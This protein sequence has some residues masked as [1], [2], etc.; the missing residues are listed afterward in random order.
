MPT[1]PITA[2]YRLDHLFDFR[3]SGKVRL[4][5]VIAAIILLQRP[6]L[7]A[8]EP[9]KASDDITSIALFVLLPFL[10]AFAFIVFVVYRQ[11][12]EADVKQQMT[13]TELKALRAQMN[14]HFIFNC[15]NSI[16]LLVRNNENKPAGEYLLKFSAIMRKVL[17]S[18]M[19]GMVTVNEDLKTLALYL[20]LE[21]LR[22]N[23][24]FEFQITNELEEEGD[25][26]MVPP[27]LVQPFAENSIWHGFASKPSG[28][29]IRVHVARKGDELLITVTDN[30]EKN[31]ANPNPE[32][33]ALKKASHSGTI[34]RER[35]EAL[36]MLKH[37]RARYTT[38]EQLDQHGTYAGCQVQL[39][40]PC[41]IDS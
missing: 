12:R 19:A 22:T 10:V 31:N 39:Y 16:Y 17:D 13:E 23:M 14:P 5:L 8:Q 29:V 37:S 15:L 3:L 41:L 11:K 30:G 7:I 6:Q 38:S 4:C 26:I 21:Q 18:S 28:G 35:L 25:T 9:A 34:I 36:N 32:L 2:F 27:L 24:K 40:L 1:Q 33:S 20:E